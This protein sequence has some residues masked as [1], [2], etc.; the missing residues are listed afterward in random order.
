VGARETA[1]DVGAREVADADVAGRDM[2][3]ADGGGDRASGPDEIVE[4]VREALRQ[5]VDPEIRIDVVTLGLIREIVVEP[6]AVAITMILTTPFCP[7]G[8]YLIQQVKDAATSAAGAEARVTM[9][10]EL[11]SPSMME[12]ADLAEWGLL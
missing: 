1:G 12:G 5:V 8:G 6:R 11:W 10:E 3:G 7:Y 2:A 9:G 4:R